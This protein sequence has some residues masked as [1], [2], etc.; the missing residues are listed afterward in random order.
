MFTSSIFEESKWKLLT[1]VSPFLSLPVSL[2]QRVVFILLEES[3]K[4]AKKFSAFEKYC[5]QESF[6][7]SAKCQLIRVTFQWY[8]GR[9]RA[10]CLQLEDKEIEK[11]SNKWESTQ[12][13]R[14]NGESILNFHP[15]NLVPQLL[16]WMMWFTILE[17]WNH[18][19]LFNDAIW[20]PI[21]SPSGNPSI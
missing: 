21:C 9:R 14:I 15:L 3:L 6:E 19:S 5:Q 13:L 18:L 12:W 8:T 20:G 16:S 7:I 11:C 10:F 17:D 4:N 1:L 2:T